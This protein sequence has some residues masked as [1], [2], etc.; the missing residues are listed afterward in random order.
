MKDINLTAVLDALGAQINSLMCDI[1][2]RDIRIEALEKELAE[3]KKG[4]GT[5]GKD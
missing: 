1:T 3:A 4:A 2:L 5:D